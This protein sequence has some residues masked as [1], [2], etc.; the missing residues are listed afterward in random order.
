MNK[1]LDEKTSFSNS[2]IEIKQATNMKR[3]SK[4]CDKYRNKGEIDFIEMLKTGF[5]STYNTLVEENNKVKNCLLSLQT[6]IESLIESKTKHIQGIKSKCKEAMLK[7]IN[8][9]LFR[10]KIIHP[11]SFK[12]SIS[13]HIKDVEAVF[14]ENIERLSKFVDAFINPDQLFAFIDNLNDEPTVQK[15][16]G[17]I[18]NLSQLEK[19]IIEI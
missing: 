19:F 15:Q 9:K 1:I 18:R 12:L 16:M 6:E 13:G 3:I 8:M 4:A 11:A 5:D 2:Y 17:Y 7:D 14:V 10:L